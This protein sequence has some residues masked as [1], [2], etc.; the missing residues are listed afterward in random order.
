MLYR[1]KITHYWLK[2][3][4]KQHS[5]YKNLNNSL[6]FTLLMKEHEKFIEEM[7]KK[8]KEKKKTKSQSR[9]ENVDKDK[10]KKMTEDILGF[11]KKNK[12]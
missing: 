12:E 5:D 3:L 8:A 7:L 11:K 6:L 1:N 10:I 2:E 4:L 9:T